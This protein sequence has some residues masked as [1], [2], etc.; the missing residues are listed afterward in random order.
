MSALLRTGGTA[1]ATAGSEAARQYAALPWRVGR[2][3]TFEVLLVTSRRRGR[4]I[5]PKG[6][7]VQGRSPAEA[8]AREAFEEAGVVGRPGAEPIGS[9][10]YACLNDDGSVEPRDVTLFGLQVKGTLL[11]WPEKGQRK[12]TWRPIDEAARLVA[13]PGLAELLRSLKPE[14]SSLPDFLR[15]DPRT[16]RLP[17]AEAGPA[18]PAAAP[19]SSH[20]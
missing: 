2:N 18:T 15:R 19:V 4:W 8:A 6:W 20:P 10:S 14:L 1:P 3:G 9:Y 11:N 16:G 17:G 5:V 13:E 12:R 7:P